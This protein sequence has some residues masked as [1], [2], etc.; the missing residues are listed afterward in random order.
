MKQRKPNVG[1]SKLC[2]L[3][4]VTRQ[5]YYQ[6]LS[7]AEFVGIEQDLVLKEVRLIRRD[8]PRIGTRKLYVMT[9]QF[10]LTH[11]IK[12]GRDA[13]FDLL[14]LHG[15]LIRRRRR[16]VI[17]TQSNHWLKK[18]PNL[19]KDFTPTGIN[20]L[21]VSDITYWFTQTDTLYI[22]F[23]TDA[24][25]HKIVGHN[26]AQTLE[27]VESLKSLAMALKGNTELDNLIHHSD[28]GS[29]YCCFKYVN[30]LQDYDIKISMTETGDPR[31]NPVA[32]RVNGILKGEYL[33]SYQVN[34]FEQA[35][36]LLDKVIERYNQERPHMSI[37]NL[38]PEKVH[39]QQLNKGEQ[40]WKNYYKKTPQTN[41]NK[42]L[43]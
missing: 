33:E 41:E 11:Q 31:D 23:I 32:E 39:S 25:S 36:E 22:S 38:V 26:L 4:G 14:S 19:I 15:L 40:K 24:Y 6:S 3:F 10:M 13:L 28:R 43:A 7:R 8:H 42:Q 20:Q 1:L 29:Q 2:W 30:L 17:T 21:W 37:G 16:K 9:E 27:A 12:M 34:T 18:H 35:K 5:A